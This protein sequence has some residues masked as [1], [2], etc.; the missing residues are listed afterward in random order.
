MNPLEFILETR[1]ETGQ[2]S[3]E[4]R[5]KAKASQDRPRTNPSKSRVKVFNTIKDAL[6]RGFLGQIFS[7]RGSNRL[8]VITKQKWGKDEEHI[9]GGRVAKGFS[10]GT[11]PSSFKDVKQYA[12][13]T[14]ARHGGQNAR[15]FLGSK[16][17]KQRRKRGGKI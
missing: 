12:V 9:V 4:G 1:G 14:L 15:K 8:Y 10:P 16:F 5:F 3:R 13:R 6:K 7:T 2:G 17:F 11:I